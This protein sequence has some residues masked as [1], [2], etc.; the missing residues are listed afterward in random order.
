MKYAAVLLASLLMT[1]A[2][3]AAVDRAAFINLSTKVLKIEV[4]RQQGGFS[5]GSGVLVAPRRLLTNCHVTRDAVAV[6]AYQH[7]IRLRAVAQVSDARRDL[8]LLTVPGTDNEFVELGAT[9]QLVEGQPVS[10]IGYTGGLGIQNSSGE[11]VVL[12]P[13]DGSK[14]IQ[15]TNW[16]SSGAS[17]GGLFDDDIRLV[18][19]MTFRLR[20][21]EAHY[22]SAPVEWV[23]ALLARQDEATEIGPLPATDLAYWQ[24]PLAQQPSFLQAAVLERDRN[25]NALEALTTGWLASHENDPEPWYLRGLALSQQNRLFDAKE[26]LERSVAISPTLGIAWHRLGLVY[27]SLGMKDQAQSVQRRLL[28]ISP[29]LASELAKKLIP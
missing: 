14:I 1:F 3:R 2:A 13:F 10:A 4:E 15:S 5:L 25:W 28:V 21:G 23:K 29:D 19:V 18:G 26:S 17:G 27:A 16:F 8:C 6:Y 22:F 11:V 12:H 7:G 20:G 9:T 24:Q